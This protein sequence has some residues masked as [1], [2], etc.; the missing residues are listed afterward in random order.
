MAD[1]NPRKDRIIAA[2]L[3]FLCVLALLL[4]LFFGGITWEREELA[5]VSTPEIMEIEPSFYEPEL[6][7]L[8]EEDATVQDR[9]P[10]AAQGEPAPSQEEK[11]KKPE[12]AENPSPTPTKQLNTSKK[13]NVVK[14]DTAAMKSDK[15]Q[16]A[17]ALAGKFSSN[18][19]SSDNKGVSGAGAQGNGVTGSAKG[20]EFLSCPLPSVTLRHKTVVT[21]SV[22]ID[23]DGK[24]TSASA[25]GSADES[26]RKKCEAAAR[27]AKWS[28]KKG[29]VAT[30]GSITFTIIPK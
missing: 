13:E 7:N 21:V 8:G 11:I 12:P 2:A 17:E 30:R 3:T 10:E 28:P 23:A 5:V 27:Q 1:N 9:P 19:G 29:A 16:A 18:N 24:V 14:A 6:L 20:R 15:R 4:F 26:I 25:S 22:T